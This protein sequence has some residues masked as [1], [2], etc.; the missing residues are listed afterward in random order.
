MILAYTASGWAALF[1]FVVILIGLVDMTAWVVEG[2]VL[3]F[4]AFKRWRAKPLYP[5]REG[6]TWRHRR[7][8]P[9]T[10]FYR[11]PGVAL[12]GPDGSAV[13][14]FSRM[15][16]PGGKPYDWEMESFSFTAL[17]A[18]NAGEPV[19]VRA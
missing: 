12:M 10:G 19:Q 11:V 9:L 18:V 8:M 1:W 3:I 5:F 15:G 13:V 17:H 7:P 6:Y 4:R 2:Y 16:K 14:K